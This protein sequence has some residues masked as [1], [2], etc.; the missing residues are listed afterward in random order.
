MKKHPAFVIPFFLSL[1]IAGCATRPLPPGV[2]VRRQA[3]QHLKD[4]GATTASA[5]ERA[6]NYLAA[7]AEASVLLGRPE[8]AD[9][10]EIYNR[11]A[12]ELTVLL[13]SADSGKMWNRPLTVSSGGESYRVSFTKGSREG[14]WDPGY[15]TSFTPAEEVKDGTIKRRNRQDG[16]GGALVG[17]HKTD[18]LAPFSPLVGITA[19]VTSIL[20]FKG[21]DVTLTLADPNEKS[22]ALVAGAMRPMDADF[23]APL[24]YY[25]QRSEFWTGLMGAIRVDQYMKT[26][27]L[28]MLQPYQADRIPLIF[29]HGLISTP[30]MWRN[31]INEIEADP[32]LRGRYQCWVFSYPTG[33]PPAYSAMRFR[34]ELDRVYQLY[35]NA[36]DCVLVGHSMG[37]IVSRM[38]TVSLDR[39]SYDVIEK[40][41]AK[42]FMDAAE[43]STLIKSC[44]VFRACPRV[45]RVVFICTP[46]RGSEMAIGSLGELAIR[47]IALPVS[48]TSTVAGTLGNTLGVITG[49]PGRLPNSVTGLSPANP[50]LKVVDNSPMNAPCHSIIGDRGKGDTPNSSDGVVPYWSSHLDGAKSEKIVP[51]PHGS[52]ELPETID[53]LQRILLLHLK[54]SGGTTR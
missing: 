7:A 23:S 35:P 25:P 41:K 31:V 30:L 15:F 44:A 27:G 11:A 2:G 9:A 48:I 45:D 8:S 21:R 5:E 16:I 52:C 24:A 34:E 49:D 3:L 19:P 10:L 20:E 50:M 33:N 37:G 40:N 32:T 22:K 1:L 29:V 51:G 26:T 36:R 53:E 54:G 38:Q 14:V 18:P 42:A 13:R 6:V 39:G 12:A 43:K 4:A 46:H 47:L 17:V 28:Y